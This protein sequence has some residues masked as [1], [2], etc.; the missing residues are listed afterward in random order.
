M[1]MFDALIFQLLFLF[2][3]FRRWRG[4]SKLI[5]MLSNDTWLKGS[6]E[7]KEFSLSSTSCSMAQRCSCKKTACPLEGM[8]NFQVETWWY[9]K[10]QTFWSRQNTNQVFN[11]QLIP[12]RQSHPLPLKLLSMCCYLEEA[13][14]IQK[15]RCH[16][17]G[18]VKKETQCRYFYREQF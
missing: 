6:N 5:N 16:Q 11:L 17:S 9:E 18:G 1:K 4:D 3:P 8:Q 7:E 10:T 2:V 12:K 13:S 14:L 15:L